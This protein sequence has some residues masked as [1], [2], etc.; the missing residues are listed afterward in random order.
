MSDIL[1][2]VS[3]IFIFLTILLNFIN[4]EVDNLLDKN[5]PDTEKKVERQNFRHNLY[6]TLLFKSFPIS[7]IFLLVFYLFL[8]ET[9]N[10]VN[11]SK[12]DIWN[13]KLI[14]TVLFFIESG[15]LVLMIYSFYKFFKLLRKLIKLC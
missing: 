3:V 7:L 11:N 6:H 2:S 10:I 12:F 14:P 13:F 8:P 4:K 5:I 1:S 9:I 15:F